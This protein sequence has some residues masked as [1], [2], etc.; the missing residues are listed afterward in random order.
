MTTGLVPGPAACHHLSK[1]TYKLVV[2]LI[3]P[4]NAAAKHITAVCE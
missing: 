3:R 2:L 1:H 4:T